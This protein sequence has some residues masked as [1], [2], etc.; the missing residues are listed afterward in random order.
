MSQPPPMVAVRQGDASSG[1]RS[2]SAVALTNLTAVLEKDSR[3]QQQQISSSQSLQNGG[4]PTQRFSAL[5]LQLLC[6]AIHFFHRHIRSDPDVLQRM[7]GNEMFRLFFELQYHENKA[8]LNRIFPES[9]H[10]ASPLHVCSFILSILHQGI[11]S[12]S[13][14]IVSVIYL[15]RFKESSHITLHTCTWR[16]L[17]LTSLLLADKMWEDKPVRNS[18]LA[19]LFPVL[20]NLE[21][22]VMENRF[23]NEIGFNVLVKPDLFCSFC[24]KLLGETVRSELRSC[25]DSSEYAAT[26]QA[27]QASESGSPTP[28][29]Q[30]QKAPAGKQ[31]SVASLG[32]DANENARYDAAHGGLSTQQAATQAAA[33]LAQQLAQQ[34]RNGVV[35]NHRSVSSS[36]STSRSSAHLTKTSATAGAWELTTQNGVPTGAPPVVNSEALMGASHNPDSNVPRSQSAGPTPNGTHAS[37]RQSITHSHSSTPGGTTP[38]AGTANARACAL[39]S[40]AKGN[41]FPQKV[42]PPQPHARSVSVHPLHRADSNKKQMVGKEDSGEKVRTVVAPKIA[43]HHGLSHNLNSGGPPS[44]RSLPAKTSNATYSPMARASGIGGGATS[45][46]S[47][48]GISSGNGTSSVPRGSGVH[49]PQSSPRSPG[50]SPGATRSSVQVRPSSLAAPQSAQV[51]GAQ[52]AGRSNSQPRVTASGQFAAG[53]HVGSASPGTAAGPLQNNS[54]SVGSRHH[55]AHSS[56]LTAAAHG[57]QG[58]RIGPPSSPASQASSMGKLPQQQARGHSPGGVGGQPVRGSSAPRVQGG[59]AAIRQPLQTTY[60]SRGPQQHAAVAQ[61]QTVV[62]SSSSVAPSPAVGSPLLSTSATPLH[63]GG[64]SPLM[65]PTSPQMRAAPLH[66]QHHHTTAAVALPGA[67]AMQMNSVRG[68]IAPGVGGVHQ[69]RNASPVG[70]GAG[71]TNGMLSPSVHMQMSAASGSSRGRSPPP[72]VA[73][74]LRQP[75]AVVASSRRARS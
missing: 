44:R 25:V 52:Q 10:D 35:K 12:V 26:L 46:S 34:S 14:L 28:K 45:G 72:G 60:H 20:S 21:L 9:V 5:Q 66:H 58:S 22:N 50:S 55:H 4:E 64:S 19:K 41:A 38:A 29:I 6:A 39:L 3:A 63:Y 15:S 16:P 2:G 36:A 40:L 68:G 57:G 11:F 53:S 30:Q 74:T 18:S 69:Q 31:D 43:G 32:Q 65:F 48:G 33:H 7:E 73:T 42:S 49:H 8:D 27:D 59:Q 70:I 1:G 56:S 37:L 17:F 61:Q 23:L 75:R 67:A 24:E 54:N 47:L 71:G 51:V 62:S 13:A